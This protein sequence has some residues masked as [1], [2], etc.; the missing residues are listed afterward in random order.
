MSDDKKSCYT[1]KLKQDYRTLLNKRII[2]ASLSISIASGAL[3]AQKIRLS[4]LSVRSL[5]ERYSGNRFRVKIDEICPVTF[6]HRPAFQ[7]GVEYRNFDF[8]TSVM[9]WLH[10]IKIW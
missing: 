1:C 5:R 2:S 3:M 7:N 9:I 8:E 4:H 10:C 6:T